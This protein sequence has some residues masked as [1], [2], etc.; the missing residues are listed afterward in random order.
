[1]LYFTKLLLTIAKS[2]TIRNAIIHAFSRVVHLRL[3]ED[4]SEAAKKTRDEILEILE[5]RLRDVIAYTRTKALQCWTYLCTHRAIP[6]AALPNV[7]EH[8]MGRLID[9]SAFVR[10]AAVQFLNAVLEHNPYEGGCLKRSVFDKQLIEVNKKIAE[11]EDAN[12]ALLAPLENENLDPAQVA[13]FNEELQKQPFFQSFQNS[14][15]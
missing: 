5:E 2:Y 11:I 7:I 10:K 6:L 9:K 1:M 12:K 14:R 8:A 13:A 15:K 4:N 3:F